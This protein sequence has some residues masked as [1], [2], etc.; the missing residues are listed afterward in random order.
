[1][2]FIMLNC[3]CFFDR[4]DLSSAGTGEGK[5]DFVDPAERGEGD[6][7]AHIAPVRKMYSGETGDG[8]IWSATGR[9]TLA[10]RK[11]FLSRLCRQRGINR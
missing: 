10:C 2:N 4:T 8:P 5:D 9:F 1:M 6:P 3:S 11:D 7:A